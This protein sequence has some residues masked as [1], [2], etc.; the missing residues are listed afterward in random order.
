MEYINVGFGNLINKHRVI[1]VVGPESAPI[2]RLIM[3]N[4]DTIRL[5]DATCGK[6]TRSVIIMDNESIVLSTLATST[7]SERLNGGN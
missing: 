7:I 2:K 4:R 5:I 3:E 1:A 6:K